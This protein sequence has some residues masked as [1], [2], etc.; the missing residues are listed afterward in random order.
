MFVD[1][2]FVRG[3][4]WTNHVKMNGQPCIKKYT[5]SLHTQSL[6]VHNNMYM[7]LAHVLDISTLYTS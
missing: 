6:L 2:M 3:P 4:A 7:Y 5:Q 1:I